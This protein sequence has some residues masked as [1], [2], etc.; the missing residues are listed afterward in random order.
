MRTKL[1]LMVSLAV[2][3][4]GCV[5]HQNITYNDTTS[6]IKAI[7]SL[8]ASDAY[9]VRFASGESALKENE[10]QALHDWVIEN[11]ITLVTVTGTGGADKYKQLGDDRANAIIALLNAKGIDALFKEYDATLTGG[12]GLVWNITSSR[13]AVYL[14]SEMLIQKGVNSNDPTTTK[15]KTTLL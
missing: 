9:V 1:A 8:S 14:N 6:T 3:T 12:Q 7:A 10:A 5:S 2:L 4:T 13:D 15:K 11:S